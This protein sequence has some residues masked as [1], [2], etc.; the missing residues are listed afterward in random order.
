MISKRSVLAGGLALI[1]PQAAKADG[2]IRI[3]LQTTVKGHPAIQVTIN[4]QGPFLFLL[5]PGNGA[6]VIAAPLANR[7]KLQLI[8]DALQPYLA[9]VGVQVYPG[10]RVNAVDVRAADLK[11]KNMVFV[12]IPERAFGAD[13]QGIV[14][15]ALL[16]K[17]ASILDLAT[18]EIRIYPDGKLPLEGFLPLPAALKRSGVNSSS[19]VL[20]TQLAGRKAM[21][22]YTVGSRRAIT[23]RSG[24]VR[25]NKLWD[26]FADY[27]NE[28]SDQDNTAND[29]WAP[30]R[31]VMRPEKNLQKPRWRVATITD[32]SIGN[33]RFE[34]VDV[35]LSDPELEDNSEG[36]DFA[37]RISAELFGDSTLAFGEKNQM[38][39]KPGTSFAG[40]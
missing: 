23:L 1:L 31:E 38:W 9:Y 2:T 26:R 17:E 40:R 10:F 3:P 5:D 34:S 7:L 24:Y 25:A 28:Y 15:S 12:R 29:Q 27:R 11:R 33:S 20:E 6:S 14:G 19:I 39:I 37:G 4:E 36:E 21:L 8:G 35:W 18:R 16:L 32:F 22:G 30:Y 13:Y